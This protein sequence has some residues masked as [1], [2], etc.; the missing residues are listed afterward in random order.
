MA[1]RDEAT[2]TFRAGWDADR[3]RDAQEGIVRP[4][5]RAAG[6]SAGRERA[7]AAPPALQGQLLRLGA[8]REVAIYLRDGT[9]WVADFVDGN[10]VLIDPGTWLRFN[11]GAPAN[12][13]AARRTAR[14]SAIPLTAELAA[15]IE[16]LHRAPVTSS[17]RTPAR[18]AKA[19]LAAVSHW[20]AAMLAASWLCLRRIGHTRIGR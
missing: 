9:V 19:V 18:F 5:G 8:H 15:R 3:P 7:R 1:A 4:P 16:S 6:N 14:E 10:G 20:R 2:L 12:V 17:G 13:R 11:C